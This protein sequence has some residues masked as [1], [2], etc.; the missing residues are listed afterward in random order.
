MGLNKTPIGP[1]NEMIWM[2]LAVVALYGA[3]GW[4]FGWLGPV[5]FAGQSAVAIV[6]LE[7][8]NY[9]EHYGLVRTEIAPGR[10]EKV[11]ARH[12][13]NSNH[14]ITNW[15][16]FSLGRHADHHLHAA[17]RYP[18]LAAEADDAPA[19]PAGYTVMFILAMMPPLWRRVMD[20]RVAAART[21]AGAARA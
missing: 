14:R 15:S 11:A 1:A 16:L 18:A 5:M 12:S 19:L 17:R 10:H 3:I 4:R 7:T 8:I 2:A 6:L 21:M 20:A 9:I 13:W